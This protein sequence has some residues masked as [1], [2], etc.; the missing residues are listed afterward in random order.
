[1]QKKNQRKVWDR[2]IKHE[3]DTYMENLESFYEEGC[4]EDQEHRV[5]YQKYLLKLAISFIEEENGKN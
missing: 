4:R 2:V 3:L 1:M 5:S